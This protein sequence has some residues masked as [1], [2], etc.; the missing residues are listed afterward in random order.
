MRK[1]FIHNTQKSIGCKQKIEMRKP[2]DIDG[3]RCWW[4]GSVVWN[5]KHDFLWSLLWK[6]VLSAW[7]VVVFANRLQAAVQGQVD[8]EELRSNV[9]KF[10]EKLV[11]ECR[12]M[13]FVWSTV[14][15]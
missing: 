8:I 2:V 9:Q 14:L 1:S 15:K 12:A 11:S 10:E 13:L 3:R 5:V 7:H 6:A 4:L